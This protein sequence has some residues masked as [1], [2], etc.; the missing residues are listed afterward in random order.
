M[1]NGL[2]QEIIQRLENGTLKELSPEDTFNFECTADCMGN[3]CQNIDIFLDPWDVETMARHLGIS[4]REFVKTYCILDMNEARGWP[5]VQ[6]KH[7][8]E[9]P[10]AFILE[11]GKCSIYP[12]RSRNC[13]TAPIAR[14]VRFYNNGAKK[15]CREKIFMINPADS[16]QGYKSNKT[17]TVKEWLKDSNAYKYYEL[18]DIYLELIDYATN[19]LNT[20]HWLSG[21]AMQM[22]VPFLFAPDILRARLRITPQDVGHEDFYKRRMKALR[23]I[24]TE[25]AA[26]LGYGPQAGKKNKMGNQSIMEMVKDI[27]LAEK[28]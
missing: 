26:G 24:L 13:R 28:Q 21:P 12:A 23:V 17:W 19:N 22:M 27:L 16:C 9:G 8:A 18:S 25:M 6:L 3:C 2:H 11:D 5:G 7:A 15:E 1:A 10:C 20:R 4:G 14:A